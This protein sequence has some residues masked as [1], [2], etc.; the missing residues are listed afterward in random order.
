MVG[1]T[2]GRTCRSTTRRWPSPM[3]RA[4]STYGC[5]ATAMVAPRITREL[6]GGGD[7]GESEDD[8]EQAGPEDRHDREDDDEVGER[9]PRVDDALHDEVVRPAEVA[10]RDA[11]RG[12]EQ[13]AEGDGREAHGDRDA[14]AVDDAAPEVAAEVVGA[15]PVGER[16]AA[17]CARRGSSRRSRRARSV[18]EGGHDAAWRRRSG[19][20]AR[21]AACAARTGRRARRPRLGA[22][23]RARARAGR[24][25]PVAE[26]GERVAGAVSRSRQARPLPA[27]LGPP[28]TGSGGR[29]GHRARPRP[30]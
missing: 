11:D 7:D 24:R 27:R 5:C 14:G 29:G 21:R 9:H 23:R 4:A 26:P 28:S 30:G 1:T 18:G 15:E 22:R 20:P 17:S 2:F 8:V 16:S 19:R 6:V 13:G 10:A 12:R 25:H 3:A